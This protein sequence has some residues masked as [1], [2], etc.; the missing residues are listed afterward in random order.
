[1]HIVAKTFEIYFL[2]KISSIFLIHMERIFTALEKNCGN[3]VFYIDYKKAFDHVDHG[4]LLHK[5]FY[6]GIRG[7]VSKLIVSFSI[8]RTQKITLAMFYLIQVL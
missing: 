3:D 7:K 5:L 4:I 2:A 8:N 1:M 6:L